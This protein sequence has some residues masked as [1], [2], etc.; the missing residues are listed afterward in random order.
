MSGV[1]NALDQINDK[2]YIKILQNGISKLES[3]SNRNNM[4]NTH[5][6]TQRENENKKN[7]ELWDSSKHTDLDGAGVIHRAVWGRNRI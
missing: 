6:H 3:F 2:L 5:T 1:K 4:K 7:H